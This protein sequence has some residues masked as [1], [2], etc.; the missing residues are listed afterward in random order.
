MNQW[1]IYAHLSTILPSLLLGPIVLLRRKGDHTHRILGKV[2]AILMLLAS[3]LSFGILSSGH[4]S[5]L[6]GLA[7]FTIFSV[8]RGIRAAR[9]RDLG[10]HKASMVGSYVGTVAAFVFALSPGR[11]AGDWVRGTPVPIPSPLSCAPTDSLGSES[12]VTT[13]PSQSNY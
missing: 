6:H 5:W 1:V 3:A 8:L 12:C 11:M 13:P 4:L 10:Q 7:A 9:R 2:W